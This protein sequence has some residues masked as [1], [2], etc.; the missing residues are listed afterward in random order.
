MTKSACSSPTPSPHLRSQQSKHKHHPK[1][2]KRSI[3]TDKAAFKGDNHGGHETKRLSTWLKS[4]E[5][6]T[7]CIIF[8]LNSLCH[9]E[10]FYGLQDSFQDQRAKRRSLRRLGETFDGIVSFFGSQK[11]FYSLKI[12]SSVRSIIIFS[13]QLVVC[14]G[15]QNNCNYFPSLNRYDILYNIFQ[16]LRL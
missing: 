13:L 7:L 14:I 10:S 11:Q 8:T 9:E 4:Q 15:H 6:F 3:L 2:E 12:C 1:A 5:E 16:I